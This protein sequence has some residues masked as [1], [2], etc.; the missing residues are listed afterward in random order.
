MWPKVWTWAKGNTLFAIIIAGALIVAVSSVANGISMRQAAQGYLN[1]ARGWAAAYQRDTAASKKEYE[2]KI[3][4]LTADRDAYRKKWEE[5]K[6]R[7]D[8]PWIPPK[9]AK[10]LQER[11]NKLGYRGTLK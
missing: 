8:A 2:G 7:M 9:G 11:F 10:A 3:R 1:L 4:T 6:G 5:A